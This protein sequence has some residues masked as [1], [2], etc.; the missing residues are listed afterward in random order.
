MEQPHDAVA[1]M[2]K[3]GGFGALYYLVAGSHKIPAD[4]KVIWLSRPRGIKWR[5]VMP[6]IMQSANSEVAVWRR[7]MVLGPSS[8]FAV[9][10][11]SNLTLAVPQG[12]NYRQVDRRRL[13]DDHGT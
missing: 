9:I 8:E 11:P 13:H 3:H 12:W 5:D 7:Q 6:S 10:G 4:S 2:T 1:R